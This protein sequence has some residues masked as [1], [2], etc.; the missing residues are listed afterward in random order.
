MSDWL[1]DIIGEQETVEHRSPSQ[2][3]MYLRCPKQWAYRYAE[4]LILPPSGAQVQGTSVHSGAEQDLKH[5][6]QN[7]E[8]LPLNDVLDIVSTKF[9]EVS[10]DAEFGEDDPG[11]LKD[12]SIALGKLWREEL[13]PQLHPVGVEEKWEVN[14]NGIKYL[15]IKDV[16][17]VGKIRDLKTCKAKPPA[18]AIKQNFQGMSYAY[19]E[20]RATGE[21][22][23]VG[24][25]YLVKN[26]TPKLEQRAE[27]YQEHHMA[28]VEDTVIQVSNAIQAAIF[29]RKMD[30]WHCGEKWCG[31]YHICM[32]EKREAVYFG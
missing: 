9:D 12:Q 24:F 30:G 18:D 25:D 5:K 3:N 13:A 21:I 19:A 6:I 17:E 26:K 14:I 7:G 1:D 22:P 31:Y 4:G 27:Q 23:Q 32:A 16:K 2:I 10:Q 20:Y 11:E 8:D 28:I 29:P 15:G